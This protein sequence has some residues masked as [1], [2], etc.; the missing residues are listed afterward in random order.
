[1][2]YHGDIG[3]P[4]VETVRVRSLATTGCAGNDLS[5]KSHEGLCPAHLQLRHSTMWLLI[6]QRKNRIAEHLRL[7]RTPFMASASKA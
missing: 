4:C 5:F 2:Q 3:T 1:M 7:V 6:N